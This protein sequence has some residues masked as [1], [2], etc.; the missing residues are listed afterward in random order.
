[1]K[2]PL[3]I[4]LYN[5]KWCSILP[6]T[7]S[8]PFLHDHTTLSF[9]PEATSTF[10]TL[11][12]HHEDTNSSPPAPHFLKIIFIPNNY[13]LTPSTLHTSILNSDGLFFIQYTPEDTFKSQW[14]LVHINHTETLQLQMDLETTCDYYVT[15]L[16]RHSSDNILYDV[17]ARWFPLW[18]A[19][20]L[21][22]KFFLF[23]EQS[24]YWDLLEN[25]NL[26]NIFFGRILF[27]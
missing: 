9:S 7:S 17:E 24:I 20:V 6:N 3:C 15:F 1:M 12:K 2:K 23:M 25:Q 5:K 10:S 27:T 4:E 14:F 13:H 26:S 8:P 16:S 18:Y 19:Y 21:D 22:K 11:A